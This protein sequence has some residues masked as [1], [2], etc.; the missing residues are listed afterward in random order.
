MKAT[1][2]PGADT[3]NLHRFVGTQRSTFDVARAELRAGQKRSHWMW[4]I[5]SQVS[6]LGSSRTAQR[7]AISDLRDGAAYLEHPSWARVF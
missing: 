2:K 6:G 7:F 5:F 4:F 3:Y 1:L